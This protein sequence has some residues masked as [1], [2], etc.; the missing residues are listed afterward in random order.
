MSLIKT[1]L[2]KIKPEPDKDVSAALDH[3]TQLERLRKNHDWIS[4]T[5]TQTNSSYQSLILAIDIDNHE[6]LIDELYPPQGLEDLQAGDSMHVQSQTERNPVNFYTRVLARE[7]KDGAP[8]F[9]LELPEEI[10]RNHSRGAYRVYVA[11]EDHLSIDLNNDA[12]PYQSAI[13]VINLSAD[14]IK[15]SFP[16]DFTEL[17]KEHH[18]FEHCLLRLP[19]G[20]DIECCIELRNSYAIRTPQAHCLAGGKL[21]VDQPQQRARLDQY[22]ASVQRKQRRREQRLV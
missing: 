6:L 9:R 13:R 18:L 8:L 2:N 17:L 19:T 16:N 20:A 4:V 10:G 7:F 14:G 15:L 11:N 1:L 22:L 12:I 21:S 5:V 3:Y